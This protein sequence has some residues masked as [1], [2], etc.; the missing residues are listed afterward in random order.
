MMKYLLNTD[1]WKQFATN[2]CGFLGVLMG[3]L[4][5]LNIHYKWLTADSI[6]AFGDIIVAFGTLF[7]GS[8]GIF[9]NTYMTNRSKQKAVAVAEDYTAQLK[10][11][12]QEELEKFKAN[13][14]KLQTQQTSAETTPSTEGQAAATQSN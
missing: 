8:F 1:W 14:E 5:I 12:E 9:V 11:A 10:A 7:V 4:A 13:L 6:N 2:F 3:A